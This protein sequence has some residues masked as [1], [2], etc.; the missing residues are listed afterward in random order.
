MARQRLGVVLLVP[1]P[2]A[3]EVAG[4]RRALGDEARLRIPPHITLV[5]PVNVAGRDLQKAFATVR[6]AAA[7]V[8]PLSLRLGPVHTFAPVN[9]V[10][11]LAVDGEDAALDD[12]DRL[13]QAC[14]QGSLA[15][16]SEH[17][18][19]PHVTIADRLA[20]ARLEAVAEVLASF[21]APVT[22]DRVHV[23]AEQPG[24]RWEPVADAPLGERP[25]ERQRGSLPL[26]F[27]TSGRPDPE[28]AGLLAVTGDADGRPFSVTARREEAVVGASWG[29][30]R[31]SVLEIADLAV[32][33][34]HRGEG[35]G[36]HLVAAIE[37]LARR[38]ECRELGA[39]VPAG[40]PSALFSAAGFE[41]RA[42]ALGDGP[43]RWVRH[44]APAAGDEG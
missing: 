2:L 38:R 37:D 22:F 15:R 17:D 16:E 3:T 1:Q 27:T 11:Y 20:A 26:S 4:V 31:G 44:L 42:P 9:P 7:T 5:P 18:F 24:R 43:R 6:S 36:R 14:L 12:L 39:T 10:A 40:A 35:I 41:V 29:W 23:L 30:S 32:S 28:A 21:A 34:E 13:R 25:A 33:P 8:A 19:V